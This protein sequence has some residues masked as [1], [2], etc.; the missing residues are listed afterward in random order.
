MTMTQEQ[1][2]QHYRVYMK[3]YG[4]MIMDV[5]DSD[6]AILNLINKKNLSPFNI[7]LRELLEKSPVCE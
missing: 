2:I 5:A 6:E 7:A 3:M 1:K 4:Q